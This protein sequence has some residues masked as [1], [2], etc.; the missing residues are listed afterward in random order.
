MGRCARRAGAG[1]GSPARPVPAG[2]LVVERRYAGGHPLPQFCGR[3]CSGGC[4]YRQY[5]GGEPVC[6]RCLQRVLRADVPVEP[7]GPHHAG[8]DHHDRQHADADRRFCGLREYQARQGDRDQEIVGHRRR[9][10]RADAALHAERGRRLVHSRIQPAQGARHAALEPDVD[11]RGAFQHP[12]QRRG[13]HALGV[14]G[15]QP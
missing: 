2:A 9:S 3:R 12:D 14:E 13:G 6:D 1:E 10:D 15:R 5:R 8:R 4:V 7:R 11:E